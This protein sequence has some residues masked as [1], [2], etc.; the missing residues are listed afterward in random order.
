MKRIIVKIYPHYS[1]ADD[2]FLAEPSAEFPDAD[3]P[4]QFKSKPLA[5]AVRR[6]INSGM[7][8]PM[9]VSRAGEWLFNQLESHPAVKE[10]ISEAFRLRHGESCPVYIHDQSPLAQTLPWETLYES[11]AEF[12]A[13][14]GRWPIGRITD[15]DQRRLPGEYIFSVPVRIM[16]V[17]SALRVPAR[18]EWDALYDAVRGAGLAFKLRVLVSERD[19]YAHI[20]SIRDP[21]V[22]VAYVPTDENLLRKEIGRFK[23]SILHFF[24]HG[25]VDK[26]PAKPSLHLAI[27]EDWARTAGSG[28]V[29]LQVESLVKVP[30]LNQHNWLVT[31]NCC[32]S[33]ATVK[34]AQAMARSLVAKGFPVSVGMREVVDSKDAH[35]FCQVFYENLCEALKA[36]LDDGSP[37]FEVCWPGML[38]SA[39]ERLG[40]RYAGG[41]ALSSVAAE[42]KEWTLP[43]LYTRRAPVILRPVHISDR[44]EL[45]RLK[46]LD[47]CR[48]TFAMIPGAPD[49]LLDDIS[50]KEQRAAPEAASGAS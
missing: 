18:P 31:L 35:L 10:A 8:K 5:A 3:V 43:I 1:G 39:R 28:S 32:K 4:Y 33:A 15:S 17:L 19:L 9:V 42:V 22:E 46:T 21:E 7:L 44:E 45:A 49:S 40:L 27:P 24:C 41:A 2:F 11:R 23:P 36:K 6:L 47:D 50:R 13:L 29:T 37:A 25:T 34:Q 12:L 30:Y 48:E 26:K 16:A 20:E 14:D 38:S